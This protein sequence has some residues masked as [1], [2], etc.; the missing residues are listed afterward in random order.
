[1]PLI[2]ITP[3]TLISNIFPTSMNKLDLDGIEIN[4]RSADISTLSSMEPLY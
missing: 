4:N 3:N 2:Y 1:M